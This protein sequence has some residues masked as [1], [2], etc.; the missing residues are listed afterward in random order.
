MF[1]SLSLWKDRRKIKIISEWESI[2]LSGIQCNIL[3]CCIKK[4]RS[5]YISEPGRRRKWSVQDCVRGLRFWAPGLYNDGHS[6]ASCG[7]SHCPPSLP[8]QV[9]TKRLAHSLDG[10]FGVFPVVSL[11]TPFCILSYKVPL[12]S[13]PGSC[14]HS[15]WTESITL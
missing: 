7:G 1:L 11:Q 14:R 3:N 12:Q 4:H 9:V 5:Q 2:N 13:D 10:R 8:A 15:C 6:W